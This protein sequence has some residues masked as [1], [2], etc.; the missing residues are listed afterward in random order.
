MK[1]V[2]RTMKLWAHVVILVAGVVQA[3]PSFAQ[4]KAPASEQSEFSAEDAGLKRP[5]EIPEDVMAILRN[6][7]LVKNVLESEDL[8]PEKLPQSWFS[9]SVIHLSS[10]AQPDLIVVGEPPL[11][12]ANVA[13]FWIFRATGS[14]YQVVMSAPAHDLSLLQSRH[15]GL[16]DI[17]LTSMSAAQINTSIL[18]F[19]GTQ[20]VLHR[21]KSEPIR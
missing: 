12:G 9:A 5:V 21:A 10:G 14:R 6:D 17:H 19:D 4:S 2:F 1:L 20:Y 3:S 7:D 15:N 18:H 16:R 13:N 11:S 8:L